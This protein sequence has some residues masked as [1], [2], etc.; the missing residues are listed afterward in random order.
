MTLPSPATTMA[1]MS[2]MWAER[3]LRRGLAGRANTLP[4]FAPGE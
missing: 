4:D 2:A 1:V 3:F